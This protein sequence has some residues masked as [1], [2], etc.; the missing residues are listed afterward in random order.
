MKKIILGIGSNLGN[1]KQNIKKALNL[2]KEKTKIIKI[3]NLYLTKPVGYLNQDK[4]LN[5]AIIL[6]TILKPLELLDFLKS[7]ETKLKRIKTFKNGPRT[8]DLDILYYEDKIIKQKNLIIP[9]PRLYERSFVLEPLNEIDPEFIDPVL[10]ININNI[11]TNFLKNLEIT[12]TEKSKNRL[13]KIGI[14]SNNN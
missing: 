8:I 14:I 13:I 5:G 2:I 4:F 7:I 12:S 11:W 1:K 9:H 6:N 10:K 3:S